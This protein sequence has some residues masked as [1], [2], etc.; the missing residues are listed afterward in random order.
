MQCNGILYMHETEVPHIMWI[1]LII[2][3]RKRETMASTY[4]IFVSYTSHDKGVAESLVSSL[5]TN[6]NKCWIAPRNIDP[7]ADYGEEI[8][9]GIQDSVMF[10]LVFSAQS[11]ES[12][13][14]LREVDRAI[15][16]DKVIVPIKIDKSLPT[17]GM[18]YR[19]CTV[20]WIESGGLPI[21][22]KVINDTLTVLTAAK[23]REISVAT[24]EYI[25]LNVCSRCGAQYAE[26]D[27]SGCSFH[28]H[29]PEKIGNTGPRRDYADIWQFP[30]CDQ[31]Y[32]GTFSGGEKHGIYDEQPPKS[33]GCVNGRHTPKY[34]FK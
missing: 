6:G 34:M 17:G 20:Q 5:E 25:I 2:V 33:P 26:H 8:I 28:P 7:G 11:N 14:V 9:K 31:K 32:V 13:H 27:P 1:N 18:D 30:C 21:P 3:R 12:K 19:L 29:T 24:P 10:V 4:D 16:F 23:Q 22:N 15:G